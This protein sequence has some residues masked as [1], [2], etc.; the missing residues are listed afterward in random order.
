MGKTMS[1]DKQPQA[2]PDAAGLLH[3][4]VHGPEKGRAAKS[5]K[6]QPDADCTCKPDTDLE[7]VA[8]ECDAARRALALALD[9]R[10]DTDAER[11][12]CQAHMALVEEMLF[13]EGF[14]YEGETFPE[15]VKRA[16]QQVQRRERERWATGLC[17]AH[18]QPELKEWWVQAALK[19]DKMTPQ[20]NEL[21]A[22]KAALLDGDLPFGIPHK[23]GMCG[24]AAGCLDCAEES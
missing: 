5:A 21:K 2:R 12:V 6:A 11:N 13:A 4:P 3:D 17:S 8:E 24:I 7:R 1:D 18:Q 9:E 15:F 23:R 10:D 16:F 14:V 19:L 20:V 22:A